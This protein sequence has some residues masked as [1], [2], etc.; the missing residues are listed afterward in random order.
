M[1]G[2]ARHRPLPLDH[3]LLQ[4]R[5]CY[6]CMCTWSNDDGAAKGSRAVQEVTTLHLCAHT[7]FRCGVVACC[8][9]LGLWKLVVLQG[10]RSERKGSEEW[11]ERE[12]CKEEKGMRRRKN[13]LFIYLNVGNWRVGR[14]LSLWLKRLQGNV[15]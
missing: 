1:Q 2:E 10:E 6:K 14:C 11:E 4:G 5:F 15:E 13:N 8:S 12:R 3:T 7:Q 9:V